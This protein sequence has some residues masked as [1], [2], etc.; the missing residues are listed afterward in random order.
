MTDTLET[1]LQ[2]R[3]AIGYIA[4]MSKAA[5]SAGLLAR[6]NAA[7][8]AS[9]EVLAGALSLVGGRLALIGA[10]IAGIIGV[11]G[12]GIKAFADA[13]D[14]AL[15]AA[16][17]LRNMGSSFPIERLQEFAAGLQE[18]T[19]IDDEAII[20]AGALL[21]RFR[22]A[23]AQIPNALKAI[24]DAAASTGKSMEEIAQLFG[25]GLLPN[26]ARALRSIG[27]QFTATGD[28][29]K[30]TL[31]LIQAFNLANIGT[32]EAR[33]QGPFGVFQRLFRAV[34]ELFEALG[35]IVGPGIVFSAE[36]F[37]N[38]LTIMT[39]KLNDL[40][41]ILARYGLAFPARPT[42]PGGIVPGSAAALEGDDALDALRGIEKNTK[43]TADEIVRQAFGGPGTVGRSAATVRALR[44][45][46]GNT[47]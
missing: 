1:L 43:Q 2:V 10:A 21:A 40:A 25:R 8:T 36:Q 47:F 37:I 33:G 14:A 12:L 34:G 13:N 11:S 42:V 18:L 6:A 28:R 15:R 41:D 35:R 24:A 20:S 39:K 5:A 29:V 4:E 44:Q 19:G 32:A 27:V 38:V 46:L 17:V 7:L 26:G 23:G 45:A 3:G 31:A 9:T 30:D 22:V 16:I